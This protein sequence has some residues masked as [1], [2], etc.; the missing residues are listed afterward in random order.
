MTVEEWVLIVPAAGAGAR[1]G[2]EVPKPYIPVEGKTILEHTLGRFA[3][4]PGLE[5]VVVSTSEEFAV[6][7]LEVLNRL[8]PDC[9]VKVAP[10][11][12]ERQDSIRN[13]LGEISDAARLIAVH[14]AVRPFVAKETIKSCL[15]EASVH[16]GAIAAVPAKDTVKVAGPQGSIAAT[17]DRKKLWQAQTPQVFRA[18]VIRNAYRAAKESGFTGTDDASLVERAGGKVVLVE[19]SRENFKI[20]YPLDLQLAKLLLAQS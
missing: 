17:P 1:L 16:G 3:G 18:G 20:T 8:F 2:G 11:G 14:D 13:A 5:E 9:K 10:G 15:R 4:I 19:G 12:R 7:T 6:S